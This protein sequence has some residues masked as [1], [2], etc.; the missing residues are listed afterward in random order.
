M[1]IVWQKYMIFCVLLYASTNE[2][3][4]ILNNFNLILQQYFPI[5]L[6][7]R[8]FLDVAI[9]SAILTK[10]FKFYNIFFKGYLIHIFFYIFLIY[11]MRN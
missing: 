3:H 2:C 11:N 9:S 4:E 6:F 5:F 10:R 1:A 7:L 8:H